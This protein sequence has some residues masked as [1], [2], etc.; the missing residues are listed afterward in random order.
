MIIFFLSKEDKQ[1]E[2]E[3]K[4]REKLSAE[5]LETLINEKITLYN[6]GCKNRMIKCRMYN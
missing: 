1:K 5:K 3:G 6:E 4:F 2:L